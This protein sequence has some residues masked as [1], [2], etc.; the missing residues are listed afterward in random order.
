MMTLNPTTKR[1]G[2]ARVDVTDGSVTSLFEGDQ[3]I[4]AGYSP[5]MVT[6]DRRTLI[7]QAEDADHARNYWLAQIGKL[8]HPRPL[9][10]LALEVTRYGMGSAQIIQ[11]HSIDGDTLRGVLIY[12]SDYRPGVR[13][14]LIVKVY[15]GE[16]LSDD[17]N[18]FGYGIAPFENL[19]VFASRG[20]AI[21][22]A[23][24]RLHVGTPMF[25]LLKSVMPAVDRAIEL[26][27]AD[28]ARIGI[29]GHSYGG[30][31]TLA[32][33]AQSSQFRAA[34]MRA[35]FGDLISAYGELSPSGANYELALAE[36][37]QLRMGGTPWQ[38]RQRYIDNSPIFFLDRIRTPLLIT[39]GD[40]DPSV[41]SFLSDEVFT[42][43][44]RLGQRVEYVRYAGE[45]HWEGNWSLANQID[46]LT[47][48]VVWFD[49]YLKDSQ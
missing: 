41:A 19:Q 6:P 35:G 22:L 2:F 9:T 49:R 43:L 29:M 20:Y 33:I 25:D 12:P 11:W 44:R 47:R 36:R 38:Y 24:S 8:S 46:A 26:G 39:H 27:I 3:D 1:M 7:Y 45:G 15:G 31:S 14:P 48:M 17:L 28:P 30:Y 23:D 42:G 4:A 16:D 10:D 34:I 13:Y 18:R 21:L 40:A 5:P 37:G 32:L